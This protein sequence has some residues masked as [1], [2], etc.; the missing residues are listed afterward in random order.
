MNCEFE[1]KIFQANA[2]NFE[3]IAMLV[4]RYQAVNNEVYRQ[5]LSALKVNPLSISRLT[6]VPFLPISFFKTQ[7]VVT[8][9][10]EPE[11]VFES[12]GTTGSVSSKHFVKNAG[13]YRRSFM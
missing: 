9:R 2:V 6:A 5:Y 4:F 8:G 13:L 12:S 11:V 7:K 10:F 3:E 1:D